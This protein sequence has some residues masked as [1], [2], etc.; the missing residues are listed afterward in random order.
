MGD[1]SVKTPKGF[2][3]VHCE[4]ID[5]TN[6]EAM[7][8]AHNGEPSG[9]WIWAETQSAGRGRSGRKWESARGNLFASLLLR[10]NCPIQTAL[11]LSFVA[12][13]ALHEAVTRIA[14][15]D[16]SRAFALKWPN[17]LLLQ[18]MKIGG[19]LIESF[20]LGTK[21]GSTAVIGTGLN[22]SGHPNHALYPATDLAAHG[23][24]A[25]PASVLGELVTA[26]AEWLEVW[27]EGAG[28]AAIREA[29]LSRSVQIGRPVRIRLEGG[30]VSG[31]FGGIDEMGSMRLIDG[32]G[33]EKRITAGDVF[34][35]SAE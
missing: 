9:L 4:T 5:S 7:R 34:L 26:M 15:A 2:R 21:P 29:W 11:Q 18:D 3:L 24:I 12:G 16:L 32:E 20:E 8:R 33:A 25:T 35:T 27:D 30:D 31:V 14:P 22:V 1:L 17:D 23:L 13:I 10:L 6:S 28:F 19:I